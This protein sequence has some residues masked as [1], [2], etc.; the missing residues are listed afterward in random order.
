MNREELTQTISGR[1]VKFVN[2]NSDN[3]GS[4]VDMNAVAAAERIINL[5][6]TLASDDAFKAVVECKYC[7]GKGY[8]SVMSPD[9][10]ASRDLPDDATIMGEKI[11]LSRLEYRF[12]KCER[13][14]AL[15]H[16]IL[17]NAPFVI[18]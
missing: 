7:Y 14:Q 12:C 3:I 8:S 16:L 11:Q 9:V 13:G 4:V 1:L 6:S 18:D 10:V 15:K 17:S 5:V 2:Q